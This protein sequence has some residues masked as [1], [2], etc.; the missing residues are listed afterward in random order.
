MLKHELGGSVLPSHRFGANAAWWQLVILTANLLAA[1]KQLALP[2]EWQPL[3]PRRL[4]F[5]LLQ[6]AGRIVRHG[7]Q[8]ILCLARGHPGT[9]AFVAA[10]SRLFAAV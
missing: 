4:R 9:A 6:R 3:R 1:L 5:L 8:L 10:R 2:L 7:R